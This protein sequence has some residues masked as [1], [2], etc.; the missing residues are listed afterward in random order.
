MA[1]SLTGTTATI[2]V[3]NII[4][5]NL[6]SEGGHVYP[7]QLL[8]HQMERIEDKMDDQ[9]RVFTDGVGKIS[10]MALKQVS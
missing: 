7:F 10:P 4:F 6:Q 1:L 2:T 9:G 3:K 8:P 5:P